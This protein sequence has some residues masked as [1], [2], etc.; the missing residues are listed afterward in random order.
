MHQGSE[1]VYNEPENEKQPQLIPS[2][3]DLYR[4][5]RCRAIVWMGGI[6]NNDVFNHD[7]DLSELMVIQKFIF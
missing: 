5:S 4:Q 2:S 3:L 6:K 7:W 1:P